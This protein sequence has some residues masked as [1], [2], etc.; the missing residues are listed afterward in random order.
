[1]AILGALVYCLP[2]IVAMAVSFEKPWHAVVAAVVGVLSLVSL[3]WIVQLIAESRENE[4]GPS[5]D[6][7]DGPGQKLS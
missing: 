4:T 3:V 7:G 1:M 6:S 2:A 5:P